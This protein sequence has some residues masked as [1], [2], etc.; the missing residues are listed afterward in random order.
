MSPIIFPDPSTTPSFKDLQDEVLNHDLPELYRPRVKTWLN[1]AQ[2]VVARRSRLRTLTDTYTFPTVAGQLSYALPD[3]F[4]ALLS[5]VA[6]DTGLEIAEGPSLLDVT[7][8]PRSGTPR[9]YALGPEGIYLAPL[10][11]LATDLT[12]TFRAAPPELVLDDDISPLPPAW[13]FVLV[14]YALARALRTKKR[15]QEAELVWQQFE[16]DL[17]QLRADRK[18]ESNGVRQIPGR[19]LR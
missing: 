19:L 15:Y 3:N 2:Q 16:R 17:L 12:L 5:L 9:Y 13:I 10:P 14:S 6:D 11:N 7:S 1:E 8:F 18:F 4:I